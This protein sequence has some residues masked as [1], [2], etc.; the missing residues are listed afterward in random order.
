MQVTALCVYARL[1]INSVEAKPCR[2]QAHEDRVAASAARHKGRLG[3]DHPAHAAQ[4]APH[5]LLAPHP[6]ATPLPAPRA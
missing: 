6:H 1:T 2:P 5:C 4:C 3:V